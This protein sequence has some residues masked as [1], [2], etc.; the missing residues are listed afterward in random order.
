MSYLMTFLYRALYSIRKMATNNNK[1]ITD[2]M[3]AL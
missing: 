3:K 1:S 2:Y